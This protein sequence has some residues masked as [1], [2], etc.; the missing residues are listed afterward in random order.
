MEN[1]VENNKFLVPDQIT[2]KQQW[3]KVTFVAGPIILILLNVIMLL[4]WFEVEH[5]AG[6]LR[7]L[8]VMLTLALLVADIVLLV[9]LTESFS[10]GLFSGNEW[11][12]DFVSCVILHTSS[13]G[14]TSLIPFADIKNISVNHVGFHAAQQIESPSQK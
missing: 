11:H 10:N 9:V 6:P 7:I 14:R 5:S 2:L 1:K 12:F 3:D 4:F 13:H 8:M